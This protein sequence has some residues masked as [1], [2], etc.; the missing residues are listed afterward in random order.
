MNFQDAWLLAHRYDSAARL[1]GSATSLPLRRF[2]HATDDCARWCQRCCP[3]PHP[4]LHPDN[5]T[6][7]GRP[8]ASF[9]GTWWDW[10]P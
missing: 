7:I 8:S 2:A 9:R 4:P 6:T 10:L 1:R 5:V 3:P